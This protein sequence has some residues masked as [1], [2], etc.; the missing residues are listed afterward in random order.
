MNVRQALL[1]GILGLVGGALLYREY[2][3]KKS[4]KGL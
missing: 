1:K 3:R 2:Y 4:I